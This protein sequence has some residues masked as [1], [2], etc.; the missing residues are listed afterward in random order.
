MSAH[1]D[2]MFSVLQG[3]L[4]ETYLYGLSVFVSG[5]VVLMPLDVSKA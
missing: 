4:H 5:N 3:K 1:F 2:V